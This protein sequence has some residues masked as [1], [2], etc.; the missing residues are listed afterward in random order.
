MY[1][2]LVEPNKNYLNRTIYC[3]T[4]GND[5]V[6][7][8]LLDDFCFMRIAAFFIINVSFQIAAF[9]TKSHDIKYTCAY[10]GTVTHVV[11]LFSRLYILEMY[12]NTYIAK[13]TLR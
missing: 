9:C 12:K 11:I 2:T 3:K 5:N 1:N 8:T 7:K 4:I 10:V 13:D 6:G